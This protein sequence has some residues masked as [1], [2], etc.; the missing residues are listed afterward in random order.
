MLNFATNLSIKMKKVDLFAAAMA[1]AAC[2][3]AQTVANAGF[4][5]WRVSSSGA[6]TIVQAPTFW[7]GEDS[8]IISEGETFNTILSLGFPN[9]SWQQQ[10]FQDSGANAHSGMYAAKMVTKHQDT[11]GNFPGILSNMVTHVTINIAAT[12]PFVLSYTGGTPV[13][14]VIDTVSAWVKYTPA[15]AGDSGVLTVQAMKTMSGY[16]SAIGV[17]TVS[18]GATSSWTQIFVPV[19]YTSSTLVPDTMRINFAS[20]SGAASDTGS[21]L[22]ADD[23]AMRS[24]IQTGVKEVIAASQSVAVYPNPTSDLLHFDGQANQEFTCNLYAVN[25]QLVATTVIK[26]KGVMD[27]SSVPTGMYFY[28]VTDN[29]GN[30][31]QRGKIAVIK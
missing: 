19:I 2:S 13:T 20:S 31:S 23:V 27:I 25:G 17:G 12:P 22:W 29:S 10:L 7:C 15:V 26:G 21:T 28:T 5:S 11:L 16:D 30:I 4:E 18:I 6:G 3:F 8:L 24:K 14:T 1:F 9:S